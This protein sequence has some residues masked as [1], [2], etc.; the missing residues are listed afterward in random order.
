MLADGLF[1]LS[2]VTV[3]FQNFQPKTYPQI[4]SPN[5]FIPY[6]SVLDALMNV[7]PE[8]TVE[9]IAQGTTKWLTWDEMTAGK[10]DL[11]QELRTGEE[12]L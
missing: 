8:Q 1:P 12:S 2:D 10:K 11:L 9:L 6:L 7:G 5:Y 3:L 4:G